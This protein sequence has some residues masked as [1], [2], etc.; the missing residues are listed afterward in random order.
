[1]RLYDQ[2][3]LET[4]RDVFFMQQSAMALNR[5][6]LA[7]DRSACNCDA[8]R[9]AGRSRPVRRNLRDP[10]ADIQGCFAKTHDKLDLERAITAYRQGV[11]AEPDDYYWESISST[12]SHLRTMRMRA[13]RFPNACPPA[14]EIAQ[15]RLTAARL[16]TGRWRLFSNSRCSRAIG[17]APGRLLRRRGLARRPLD[18]RIDGAADAPSR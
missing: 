1:M 16:I 10:W 11:L 7:G 12:C 4:Q 9:F 5:R 2:L 6:N 15:K 14:R 3:P 18:A 8:A 17:T 13:G